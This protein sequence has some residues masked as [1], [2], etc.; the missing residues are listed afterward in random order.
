MRV[1]VHICKLGNLL[2]AI[3]AQQCRRDVLNTNPSIGA[4]DGR[5][6]LDILRAVSH[7]H[8]RHNGY[9]REGI[10]RRIGCVL[11]EERAQIISQ[12]DGNNGII[13]ADSN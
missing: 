4:G 3:V 6:Q 1:Q 13:S 11:R 7:Y 10:L 5:K 9:Q 8:W 12:G 2:P